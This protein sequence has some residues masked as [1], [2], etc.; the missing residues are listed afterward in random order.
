MIR[1]LVESRAPI[2]RVRRSPWSIRITRGCRRRPTPIRSTVRSE[3]FSSARRRDHRPPCSVTLCKRDRDKPL[4]DSD[5]AATQDKRRIPA[6]AGINKYVRL[7][8]TRRVDLRRVPLA[9]NTRVTRVGGSSE[10]GTG[11]RKISLIYRR[12]LRQSGIKLKATSLSL[13]L[14]LESRVLRVIDGERHED[15]A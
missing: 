10:S 8:T 2:R 7:P 11:S 1:T 3:G 13:F 5:E 4:S 6:V 12:P 9:I 15:T 14:S